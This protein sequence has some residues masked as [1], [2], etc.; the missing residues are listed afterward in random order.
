MS[1]ETNR[2]QRLNLVEIYLGLANQFWFWNTIYV[3]QKNTFDYTAKKIT[4]PK[5]VHKTQNHTV[6]SFRWVFSVSL[7]G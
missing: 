7:A 2:F 6:S 3:E 4:E 1:V 5:L